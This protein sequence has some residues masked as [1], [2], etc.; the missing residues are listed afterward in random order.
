MRFKP[1][2]H[3]L[4][5]Y[6][7]FRIVV[8]LH[9]AAACRSRDTRR[10]ACRARHSLPFHV[11]LL[12]ESWLLIREMSGMPFP[13]E[14]LERDMGSRG[15]H[16]NVQR[17]R[18]PAAAQNDVN[19]QI[20]NINEKIIPYLPTGPHESKACPMRRNRPGRSRRST[21]RRSDSSCC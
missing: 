8:E 15:R 7:R 18:K 6:I 9:E 19:P 17:E 20:N 12:N 13:R 21:G 1:K 11:A 2:N 10:S 16:R 14:L 5:Y 4:N 3:L